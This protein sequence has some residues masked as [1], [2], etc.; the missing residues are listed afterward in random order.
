MFALSFLRSVAVG[1][2]HVD[3]DVPGLGLVV[4]LLLDGREG[5]EEEAAGKGHYRGAAGRD[6]VVGLEF[7]EFAEGMVDVD[8][9]VEFL[10]VADEGGGNVGLIKVLLESSD[11]FGAGTCIWIRD[12][13][14]TTAAAGGALLTMGQNGAGGN[15]GETR[16]RKLGKKGR[17]IWEPSQVHRN[18]E[19][20]GRQPHLCDPQGWTTTDTSLRIEERPHVAP[21]MLRYELYYLT[22]SIKSYN[23]QDRLR[24]KPAY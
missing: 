8:G 21:A 2:R 20:S 3:D 11:V 15:G 22:P 23:F 24:L 9:G 17:A 12:G 14:A 16:M 19:A 7:I 5:P 1:F 6:L 18:E 10:D 4:D 13:H